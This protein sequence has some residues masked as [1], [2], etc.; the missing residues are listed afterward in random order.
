MT[1]WTIYAP[2]FGDSKTLVKYNQKVEYL[3]IVLSL[4][5]LSQI[6]IKKANKKVKNAFSIYYIENKLNL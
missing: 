4:S 6:C 2:L 3:T 1:K 5:R